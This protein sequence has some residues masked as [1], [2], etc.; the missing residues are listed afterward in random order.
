ML[1]RGRNWSSCLLYAEG[2]ASGKHSSE[3]AE[4]FSTWYIDSVL[5]NIIMLSQKQNHENL[6]AHKKHDDADQ[7]GPNVECNT[8]YGM[9]S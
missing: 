7:L 9:H 4:E 3:N 5:L 2:N 8:G 1:A 6:A